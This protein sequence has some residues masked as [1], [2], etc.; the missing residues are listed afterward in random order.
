ME[1]FDRVA[2]TLEPGEEGTGIGQR[3]RRRGS[4]G[5][6]KKRRITGAREGRGG[7]KDV[8]GTGTNTVLFYFRS[9]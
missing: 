8:S 2:L 7:G 9:N 3:R 4:M 1:H 6:D 5:A